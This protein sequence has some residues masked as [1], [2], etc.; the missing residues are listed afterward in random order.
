MSDIN[1]DALPDASS[2]SLTDKVTGLVSGAT[3]NMT[4]LLVKA[5]LGNVFVSLTD[6]ATIATD[7]TLGAYAHCTYEAVITASRT[8]GAPTGMVNG[9]RLVYRIV[10]GG[11]GS[12]VITWNAVFKWSLTFPLP[13]HQS[14]VVGAK[15]QYEFVYDGAV[16]ICVNYSLGYN[17]TP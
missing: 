7:A 17:D 8:M 11:S 12:N 15:D 3:K 13:P 9:Q 2:L 4:L 1:Q 14:T 16:W 10:Q 5:L 6:A